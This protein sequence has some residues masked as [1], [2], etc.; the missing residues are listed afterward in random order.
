M[1]NNTLQIFVCGFCNS[2]RPSSY[3]TFFPTLLIGGTGSNGGAFLYKGGRGEIRE[4]KKKGWK[5]TQD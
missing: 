5:T 2:S 1:V 3:S 4:K